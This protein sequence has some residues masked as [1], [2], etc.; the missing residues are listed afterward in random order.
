MIRG[1]TVALAAIAM[2]LA[3]ACGSAATASPTIAATTVKATL[4][5][6]AIAM[7]RASAPAGTVTF[8]IE[9]KGEM[10]H[11]FV[12]IRTA[13]PADGLPVVNAE[14]VEEGLDVVDEAEDIAAGTATSLAVDLSP[15]HYILICNVS[16]HYP[17][18]MHTDFTVQ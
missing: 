12:V 10:L 14:A 3:A 2:L 18:G 6:Y 15:G 17:S 13:T 11:E 5:E 9:N 16:G 1:R 8:Q 4:T 7:D